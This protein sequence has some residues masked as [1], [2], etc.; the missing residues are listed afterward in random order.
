MSQPQFLVHIEKSSYTLFD[1]Q[2]SFCVFDGHK[3]FDD[4]QLIRIEGKALIYKEELETKFN[5]YRL[6]L[7]DWVINVDGSTIVITDKK[8]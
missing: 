3:Y 8:S 5:D 2:Y 6:N 4:L 1:D 7:N